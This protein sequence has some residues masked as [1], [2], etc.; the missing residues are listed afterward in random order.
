MREDHGK[1]IYS[2][3]FAPKGEHQSY[4]ATIGSNRVGGRVCLLRVA[5]VGVGAGCQPLA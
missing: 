4:F 2:V 5:F 3:V 1:A